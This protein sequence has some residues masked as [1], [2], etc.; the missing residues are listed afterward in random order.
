[1]QCGAP[2]SL[3]TS[4]DERPPLSC[5]LD[6]GHHGPHRNGGT[7]WLGVPSAVIETHRSDA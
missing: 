3:T 4:R 7:Q 6:P 5:S 1:M 2:L